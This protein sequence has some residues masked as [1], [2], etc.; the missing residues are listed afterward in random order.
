MPTTIT[1]LGSGTPNPAPD[2]FGTAFVLKIDDHDLIMV[3]CGPGATLKLAQ[4]GYSPVDVG[5]LFITHHHYD[6][7]VDVP[8]L[9]LCRWDQLVSF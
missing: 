1:I 7:N 6:H 8:C 9:L 2:R 4:A 3:D 5:A